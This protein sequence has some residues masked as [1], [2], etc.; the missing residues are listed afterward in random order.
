MRYIG[1]FV[2]TMGP[3]NNAIQH[4]DAGAVVVERHVS[5]DFKPKKSSQKAEYNNSH[6]AEIDFLT[7]LGGLLTVKTTLFINIH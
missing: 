6:R 1:H 2:G 3:N 7:Q 5:K 4:S